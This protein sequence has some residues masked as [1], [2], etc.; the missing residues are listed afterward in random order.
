MVFICNKEFT[1]INNYSEYFNKFSYELSNFQ[2]WA[3]YSIVNGHHTL[4]TAHTGSG[5]TLP[6]EFAIDYFK[7]KGKKVIYTGP[8]KALCNQK[9][10]DFKKKF[11]HI[12]FGIL[13]GDIKD[14][15]EADVLIM[16]TEILR[17]TLFSTLISNNNNKD[18]SLHFQMDFN[19]ELGAVVFDEVHYIGDA[20]RGNVWEQSILLLPPQIQLIMLSATIEKPEIFS[21][22]I[23]KEKNKTFNKIEKNLYLCPTNIRVVPL[24]HYS[25]ISTN[26]SIFKIAKNTEYENKLKQFVNKPIK[27]ADNS[28]NFNELNYYAINDIIN[29]LYKN[30]NFVKRQFV[31]N[32]IIRYLNNND[33]LPAI[34]F[35]FSRKNVE[36]CAH[37]IEISLF[38]DNDKTPSIIKK[39][40]ENILRN[41]LKN[42]KEYTEL[43]EFKNLITLLQKG[44]AIHHAGIMPIMRE[45]VEMLFEKGYIKLLFATETFAVGINMPT[46]T[47]IFTSLSKFNGNNGMRNLLSHEYTQM[48]GRAG[49]RGLD[50]VG[51]VIHCNNLFDMPLCNDY[52]KILTGSPK[53]LKS[54]FKISYNL[55]LNIIASNINN[56]KDEKENDIIDKSNFY[57]LKS[58]M[59]KSFIQND[60]LKEINEYNRIIEECDSKILEYKKNI[61]NGS[62]FITK[63]EILDKYFEIKNNMCNCSQKQRKKLQFNLNE[64]ENEN[65]FLKQDLEKYNK[66]FELIEEKDKTNNFAIN[67]INYIENNIE[68]IIKILVDE[69]FININY[70]LFDKSYISM[71]IQEMNSLALSDAYEKFNGFENVTCQELIC[72]FSC[73]TNISLQEDNRNINPPTNNNNI[74]NISMYIVNRIEYYKEIENK[75]FLETGIE[76]DYNYDLIKYVFDWCNCNNEQDC[77]FVIDI[78]KCET[79]IFLGEFV[80]AILKINNI[81][82]EL[83]KICET[84]Q[85]INLLQK[86]RN[87]PTLTLKYIAS[88]QSLYI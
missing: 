14:N 84:L 29:Y 22:W 70:Y 16:T 83:E 27:L 11:P 8:I 72:I 69:K 18:I 73:F 40:C 78:M 46:K 79:G 34:C 33:M 58:F 66:Y 64:I 44:I 82:L 37:E 15:P 55:V 13:T 28:G 71:Q 7:E 35:I 86:L 4:V 9:Y 85:N 68:S 43:D 62:L 53:M 5:K 48:A 10:Y 6:A 77:K 88:N 67:A 42:Y 3:L 47:V 87:I 23:E 51:H 32:D 74:K 21:E 54:Q 25:W 17:N 20:D 31:L 41:K 39:E 36:L 26:K 38:E 65:K 76:C 45:M 60:I 57:K 61:D 52:R 80:K 2:K 19:N 1:E 50:K 56:E 63:K 24:T 81:A 59:E 30:K 75:Y 49:R 12:S